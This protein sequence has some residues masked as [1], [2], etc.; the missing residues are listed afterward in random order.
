MDEAI[1]HCQRRPRLRHAGCFDRRADGGT[2]TGSVGGPLAHETLPSPGPL[3]RSWNG[4]GVGFRPQPPPPP[5]EQHSR[6]DVARHSQRRAVCRETPVS[7]PATKMFT[8]AKCHNRN[9][10]WI[11]T[12]SVRH[13]NEAN[14]RSRA[15]CV[16]ALPVSLN[17]EAKGK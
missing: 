13:F 1:H 5:R 14:K 15:L 7:P 17:E 2:R 12:A 6:L 3:A 8:W 10:C 9:I 11:W 4:E 16:G